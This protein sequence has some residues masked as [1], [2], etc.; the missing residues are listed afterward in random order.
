MLRKTG[1]E[2]YKNNEHVSAADC[3]CASQ[4]VMEQH[5]VLEKTETK[6][7]PPKNTLQH[8]ICVLF[9]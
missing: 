3:S 6:R 8:S 2:I 7:L 5:Y 1:K 4:Q 9:K